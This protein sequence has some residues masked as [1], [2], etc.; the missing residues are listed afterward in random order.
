MV[1]PILPQFHHKLNCMTWQKSSLVITGKVDYYIIFVIT[2]I[3]RSLHSW[4][5]DGMILTFSFIFASLFDSLFIPAVI[6]KLFVKCF[7]TYIVEGYG[8]Q[9]KHLY[10]KNM[11]VYIY[12]HKYYVYFTYIHTYIYIYIYVWNINII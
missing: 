1:Y 5:F 6:V 9:Q 10:Q 11:F 7:F 12:M 8:K 3:L 2:H 4:L